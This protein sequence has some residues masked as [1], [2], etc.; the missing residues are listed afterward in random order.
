MPLLYMVDMSSNLGF[1]TACPAIGQP[2]SDLWVENEPFM[3]P[4]PSHPG[5]GQFTPS[6]FM[7]VAAATAALCC[8]TV[9]PDSRTRILLRFAI[10]Q[11]DALKLDF[12]SIFNVTK[13]FVKK[14]ALTEIK[15]TPLEIS[16]I[17]E[18]SIRKCLKS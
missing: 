1:L 9:P 12:L 6:N 14:N 5:V 17:S 4:I 15:V 16:L 13:L 8:S 2:E 7:A 18:P 11:P 3:C 10:G